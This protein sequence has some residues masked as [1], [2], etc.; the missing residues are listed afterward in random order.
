VSPEKRYVC[1]HRSIE[2]G[3]ATDEIWEELSGVC[4]RLG[5]LNEAV[6][7][8]QEI[9]VDAERERVV[10]RLAQKGVTVET[11]GLQEME[12]PSDA[13]PQVPSGWK[14]GTS[15]RES[16]IREEVT[17]AAAFLFLEH[18]PF[19]LMTV[20][21]IFPLV[22]GIGGTL[23]SGTEF[24]VFPALA[25]LPVLC[26][27]VVI[28]AML[29]RIVVDSAQGFTEAPR[30]S[31]LPKQSL[32]AVMFLR[33]TIVGSA[34]LL[35]PGV[36]ACQY[37]GTIGLPILIVCAALFPLSIA[38]CQTRGDM[39]GLH[40]KVLLPAAFTVG[41]PGAIAIAAVWI[42]FTPAMCA[43]WLTEGSALYL[44]LS[45]VGPLG[46]IPLFISARLLGR[47]L[48]LNRDALENQIWTVKPK[49]CEDDANIEI[50]DSQ[51]IESQRIG[52]RDTSTQKAAAPQPEA[53]RK[54]KRAPVASAEQP[55]QREGTRGRAP[56]VHQ[57]TVQ[58]SAPAPKPKRAPARSKP[59]EPPSVGDIPALVGL[60]ELG[61][62]VLV[63]DE[64]VSAGASALSSDK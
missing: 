7:C 19:T 12:E 44:R 38:L 37:L 59:A 3:C 56:A 26:L 62:K 20:T 40:P 10:L 50:Y 60:E 31:D 43:L 58:E 15:L 4:H 8:A 16:H 49:L 29:Q 33:D 55:A 11:V 57:E 54:R 30:I 13:E 2:Q 18:I 48:Y 27:A 32:R 45:I 42:A 53:P 63:G 22:V 25:L 24:W 61:F 39:L 46:T 1:L 21:L 6:R 14:R 23:T 36:I 41:I 5:Y 28:G 64:R 52:R 17:D 35:M 47:L 9:I 34:L 51:I